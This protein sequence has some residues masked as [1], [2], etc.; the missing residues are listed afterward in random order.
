MAVAGGS[1]WVAN[2]ERRQLVRVDPRRNAVV[3]RIP[4]PGPPLGM[5]AS[6]RRLWVTVGAY[7]APAGDALGRSCGPVIYGG[8]GRPDHIIV[9]DLPMGAGPRIPARQMA[10]AIAFVLRSHRF[11]AGARTVG[12][13]VCDDW[14]GSTAVF[15]P[16]KCRANGQLY[17]RSKSVLAVIGPFNSGCALTL[18]P[19][20]NASPGGP[21][22]VISPTATLTDLTRKGL[23]TS[24]GLPASLYPAGTRNFARL[25]PAEDDQGAALAREAK[26]LGARRVDVV[27]DGDF[28]QLASVPFEAAAARLGLTVAGSYV[29]DPGAKGYAGL[30]RRVAQDRPDAVLVAG[31]LDDN[32]GAVVRDLRRHLGSRVD[33]IGSD[34][35][36]PISG[37]F[38][39]A[40]AAAR[41]IHL[42]FP[43]V[44]VGHLG[45]QGRAFVRASARAGR[46]PS[47]KRRST[48]PP[49]PSS[50]STP[51]R[52]PAA[53]AAESSMRS[54]APHPVGILG[55]IRLDGRGDIRP[56]RFT[57]V[58]AA[59]AGGSDA[60]MS[61]DGA[62]WERVV[63]P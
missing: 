9:S 10:E 50:R 56:A 8:S 1:V 25:M 37:L 46:A 29:F 28:G 42:S 3:E 41:G 52:A 55:A 49:P 62:T 30:A 5:L 6:D 59:R 54:V 32:A 47:T 20:T 18:I 57:I 51:S 45:P 63:S 23:T 19:P 11:R 27:S 35:L 14:S 43:G 13:R 39:R 26:A 38:A 34:A 40:G 15:D 7:S 17:A 2:P 4:L 48:R 60:V 31:L 36:L 33:L 61:T 58:Q 16:A 24:S 12:Y 44:D 21:L 22:A 53:R